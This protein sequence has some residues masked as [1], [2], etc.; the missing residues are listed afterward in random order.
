MYSLVVNT[1]FEESEMGIMKGSDLVWSK[2]WVAKRDEVL[3]LG[4]FLVEGLKVVGIGLEEFR[5]VGCVVGP[6]PYSSVRIA[7]SFLNGIKV[8]NPEMKAVS[9]NAVDLA[10][11][12]LF[13]VT[14][15]KIINSDFVDFL[16]PIYLKEA[17]ITVSKKEKFN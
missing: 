3:N 11:K 17:N 6:G 14:N 4:L 8:S 9:I 15:E 1:A 16:K 5:F 12:S 7:C 2:S 10:D 13:D